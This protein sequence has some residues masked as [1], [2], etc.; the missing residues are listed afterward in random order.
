MTAWNNSDGLRVE[1]GLDRTKKSKT[2]TPANTGVIRQVV[3]TITGTEL[4]LTAAGA[5]LPPGRNEVLLPPNVQITKATLYVTAAFTSGGAATLDIGLSDASGTPIDEDGLFAA[6]A[7][8]SINAIGKSV[9][10]A[11]A[12]VG[13]TI[14]TAGAYLSYDVDTAVYTAGEA[15]LVVEYVKVS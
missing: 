5:L 1:F 6:V 11:G 15:K 12:L 13:T 2:G 3:A 7:L 4:S 14:G 8:A 9:A 10:G